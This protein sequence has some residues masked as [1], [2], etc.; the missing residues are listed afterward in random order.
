MSNTSRRS[1]ATLNT[2]IG[3]RADDGVCLPG[4]AWNPPSDSS[5]AACWFRK[6]ATKGDHEAAHALRQT[7]RKG[8]LKVWAGAVRYPVR[9]TSLLSWAAAR[10]PPH[11]DNVADRKSTRLNSSHAN[12]SY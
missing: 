7:S 4:A 1:H 6:A 10:Q 11:P 5:Q 2:G 8:P 9:Y 3:K 12:I